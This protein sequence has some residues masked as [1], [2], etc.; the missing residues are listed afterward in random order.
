LSFLEERLKERRKSD[1][2]NRELAALAALGIYEI[3]SKQSNNYALDENPQRT[4]AERKERRNPGL[5]VS[6][7]TPIFIV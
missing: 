1:R 2:L 4:T 7:A 3:R 5:R 6:W